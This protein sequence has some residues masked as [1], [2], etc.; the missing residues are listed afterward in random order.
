MSCWQ[1]EFESYGVGF[2]VETNRADCLAPILES[3]PPREAAPMAPCTASFRLDF[4]A[5]GMP[6][7]LLIDGGPPSDE[8]PAEAPLPWLF[9]SLITLHVARNSPYVFVHAGMVSYHGRGILFPG[10]SFAGKTTLTAALL[11][12]GADYYSDDFAV[13]DADGRVLPYHC[14]LRIR[15]CEGRVEKPARDF[16]AIVAQGPIA[17]ALIVS[18]EYRPGADWRPE[19]VTPGESLLR[20]LEH[21]LAARTSPGRVCRVLSAVARSTA[22]VVSPRGDAAETARRIL[23]YCESIPVP[24]HLP[25]CHHEVEPCCQ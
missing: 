21:A 12:C 18:T 25:A 2:R 17:P 9:E 14:P 3:L 24:V 7:S 16:G 8:L 5:G 23:K 13:I 11:S 6:Q 4:D 19:A 20:M 22:C 1:A 10:R 15:T